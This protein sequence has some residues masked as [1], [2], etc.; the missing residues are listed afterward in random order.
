MPVQIVVFLFLRT[1]RIFVGS[2]LFSVE[3]YCLPV[4]IRCDKDVE[5]YDVAM[6]MLSHPQRAP[7]MNPV[8]V[9]KSVHNQ[10]IE[11]LWRDVFAGL[12]SSIS[13]SRSIGSVR[14]SE[15]YRSVLF[16]CMGTG[17]MLRD[18]VTHPYCS[19]SSM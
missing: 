6:Y 16:Q 10:L 1:R 8:I 15:R 12:L 4:R 11:R 13:P 19:I 2:N 5:N 9:R 18:I 14:S 17:D 7:A 3:M